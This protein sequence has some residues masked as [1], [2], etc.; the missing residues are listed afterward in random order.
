[1]HTNEGMRKCLCCSSEDQTQ[2][3][4]CVGANVLPLTTSSSLNTWSSHKIK[5]VC[6]TCKRPHP[7][8]DVIIL[9]LI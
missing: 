3:L 4:T 7:L 6:I 8:S 9:K 5:Q 1:M 2:G